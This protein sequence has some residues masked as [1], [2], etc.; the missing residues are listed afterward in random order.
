[1]SLCVKLNFIE[2]CPF[3]SNHFR[4]N[5][6]GVEC[7]G[8]FTCVGGQIALGFLPDYITDQTF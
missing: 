5:S 8:D 4:W 1:M 3:A 6:G 7:S 2:K